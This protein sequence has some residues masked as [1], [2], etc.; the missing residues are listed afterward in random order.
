MITKEGYIQQNVYENGLWVTLMCPHKYITETKLIVED[1]HSNQQRKQVGI[2]API[3][4]DTD[5]S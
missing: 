5:E 2:F 3:T 1:F 4:E